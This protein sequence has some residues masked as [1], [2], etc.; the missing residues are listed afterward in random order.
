MYEVATHKYGRKR[1]TSDCPAQ[2]LL[3]YPQHCWTRV[4]DRPIGI[5]R[6]KTLAD[7]QE[8]MRPSKHG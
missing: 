2:G 4:T 3:E 6:A 8:L 5:A 7:A 1:I